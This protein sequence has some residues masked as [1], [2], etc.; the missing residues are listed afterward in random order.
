M[1]VGAVNAL[2]LKPV[3][4]L[5]PLTSFGWILEGRLGNGS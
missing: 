2:F 4:F 3:Q 5:F 1:A